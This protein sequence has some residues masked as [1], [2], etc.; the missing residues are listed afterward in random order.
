MWCVDWGCCF[1]IDL[2]SLHVID[3]VTLFSNVG[4]D[5]VGAAVIFFQNEVSALK[6]VPCSSSF[7]MLY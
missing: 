7:I 1:T 3:G 4:K 5:K 6:L 2:S